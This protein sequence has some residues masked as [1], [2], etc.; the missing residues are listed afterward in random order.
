MSYVQPPKVMKYLM[1]LLQKLVKAQ[2]YFTT[3]K[4]EEE[5]KLKGITKAT[6]K[7]QITLED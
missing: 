1:M 6:I 4:G 7:N 5:K 2:A 3:V